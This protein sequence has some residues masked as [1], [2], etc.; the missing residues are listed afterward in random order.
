MSMVSKIILIVFVFVVVLFTGLT[1][2][3]RP[4][5]GFAD[6]F[7]VTTIYCDPAC[8]TPKAV[9]GEYELLRTHRQTLSI[10]PEKDTLIVFAYDFSIKKG[11]AELSLEDS[12]GRGLFEIVAVREKTGEKCLK[13]TKNQS[14]K[15]NLTFTPGI[16]RFRVGWE[17]K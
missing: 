2:F 3:L 11:R 4:Q 16:G 5:S 6:S 17:E 13:L 14:Y 7:R 9:E 12:G 8:R 1:F 15:L 10:E